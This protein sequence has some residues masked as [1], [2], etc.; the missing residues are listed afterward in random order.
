[1]NLYV[2]SMWVYRVEK[3]LTV[4]RKSDRPTAPR[5]VEIEF[6]E[7]Y[8]SRD[9]FVQRLTQEPRVPMIEGMQFV[10]ETNAE[11]HCMLQSA[12]F[13]PVFLPPPEDDETRD[14][15]L[16]SAYKQL[17]TAPDG[18][19]PWPAQNMGSDSPGPWQRGWEMFLAEQ[20]TAAAEAQRKARRA[21]TVCSLWRTVE[22][23][24]RL[25]GIVA[26]GE[27]AAD[28]APSEES[29]LLVPSVKEYAA[30]MTMQT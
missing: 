10:P 6:D 21:A 11:V 23:R 2:Y 1:M 30:F 17:C 29:H 9:T 5:Q 7:S 24:R 18:Q 16:L 22:V 4:R 19:E 14:L 28:E 12:L 13:R 25:A 26:E 27:N 20:K 15:R 3:N 8:P